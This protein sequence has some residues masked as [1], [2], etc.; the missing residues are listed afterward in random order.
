[1]ILTFIAEN[2]AFDVNAISKTNDRG[3]CQLQ[4]NRTNKVWIDDERWSD[5]MYQAKVCL[6]KW[7]AVPNPS[8]IW[9]GWKVRN[10]YKDRIYFINN[11]NDNN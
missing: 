8:K 4:Y 5:Y 11:Q 6:E 3:L 2:G 1:M 7:K 10:R 9:Y